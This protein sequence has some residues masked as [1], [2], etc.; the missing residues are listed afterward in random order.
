MLIDSH[1][2]LDFPDFAETLDDVVARAGAAGV[3]K[4]V[5][6][7]TR[8]DKFEAVKAMIGR[9]KGVYMAAG[10]HPHEAGEAGLKDPETL[11]SLCAEPQVVGVGETGLDYFYARSPRRAQ[12]DS[13]RAH[14]SVSRTM[15]LPLIVHTRDAEADTAQILQDEAR[16]GPFPGLIHCFTGTSYLRDAALELGF[17]ISVSGIATFKKS[18]ELRQTLAG[19]P[20]DRILVETDAPFLAPMPHRGKTNEPAFLVHT[21]QKMAEVFQMTAREFAAQTTANFHRL[22]TKVP[23]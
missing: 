2:H 10:V 14:I 22:F 7:C 11:K 8:L 9:H 19:V 13:F 5:T 6:I 20:V 12:Q 21:A 17:Y 4:I 1:C 3:E 18:E 23:V 16:R 15:G